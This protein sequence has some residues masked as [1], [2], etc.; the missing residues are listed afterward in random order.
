MYLDPPYL[1][2]TRKHKKIYEHEMSNDDHKQ[3][4]EIING[5]QANV[6]ISGYDNELYNTYLGKWNKS[7]NISV[8]EAG[9][10]RTEC[11]WFNYNSRQFDLFNEG[12]GNEC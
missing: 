10:K 7:Q 1:Y 2:E 6:L 8:D 11:L 12:V 9:N 5:L 4:L 3:L